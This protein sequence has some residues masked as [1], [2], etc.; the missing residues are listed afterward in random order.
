MKRYEPHLEELKEEYLD[1]VLRAA[2]RLRDEAQI[3][4]VMEECDRELTEEE[5]AQ[6][7]EEWLRIEA[8][9]DRLQAEKKKRERRSKVRAAVRKATVSAA[10]ILLVLVIGTSIAVAVSEPVRQSL[11]RLL[12]SFGDGHVD[13]SLAQT[14]PGE[15]AAD[16]IVSDSAADNDKVPD[17]WQGEY[18]PAYIPEGYE[19]ITVMVGGKG[20]EYKNAQGKTLTFDESHEND[21]LG[22]NTENVQVYTLLLSNGKEALVTE[23]MDYCA[24]VWSEGNAFLTVTSREPLDETTRI[25]ESIGCIR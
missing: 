2:L 25:V 18:Y 6:A 5:K 13:I 9:Y 19:L 14:D 10:C 8:Q 7:Q 22:L 20:V 21:S 1:T 4:S 3:R 17:G 16:A 12:I 15:E 23:T 24:F 11:N